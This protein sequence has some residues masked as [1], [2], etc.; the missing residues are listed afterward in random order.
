MPVKQVVVNIIGGMSGNK[1]HPEEV[2]SL[3]STGTICFKDNILPVISKVG[4][5][6]IYFF[7][8]AQAV[9]VVGVPDR[10]AFICGYLPE[11]LNPSYRKVFR[12]NSCRLPL[13]Y[14]PWEAQVD[15]GKGTEKGQRVLVPVGLKFS[16]LVV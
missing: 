15:F 14:I 13:K 10:F 6:I 8:G 16:F 4:C 2:F 7:S 9:S 1:V 5:F 3:K 12:D 11:W